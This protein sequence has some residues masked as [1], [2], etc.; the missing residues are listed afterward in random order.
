M[1]PSELPNN[2]K[3]A[4]KAA[5]QPTAEKKVEKIISGEVVRRKKPLGTRVRQLFITGEDSRNVF[6]YVLTEHIG[7]GLR[8]IL[9]DSVTAGFEKKLYGEAAGHRRRGATRGRDNNQFLN[10]LTNYGAFSSGPMGN[11]NQSRTPLTRR[12]RKL[13]NFGEVVIGT[14]IEADAVLE[15]MYELLSKHDEVTLADF[16]HMLGEVPTFQ[17]EKFGWTDLSGTRPYR[18]KG[19]GYALSLPPTEELA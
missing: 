17:D 15:T 13:H 8:D 18:A 19:G 11:P 5:A 4:A 9:F 2:S 16:L 7:P 6:E 1:E 10:T 12:D 14:K 3:K